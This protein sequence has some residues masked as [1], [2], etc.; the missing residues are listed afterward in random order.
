MSVNVKVDVDT[1]QVEEFFDGIQERILD[2]IKDEIYIHLVEVRN[3]AL[4]IKP[5]TTRTGQLTSS[6]FIEEIDGG[7][8]LYVDTTINESIY[9]PK[10][11]EYGRLLEFGSAHNKA[12][13]WINPAF[14]LKEPEIVPRLATAI[15]NAIDGRMPMNKAIMEGNQ[16]LPVFGNAP[17]VVVAPIQKKTGPQ[18]RL[19]SKKTGKFVS[20]KAL[21]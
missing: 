1:K 12:Y 15:Q 5:W 19:R 3:L 11:E 10:D 20:A 8:E 14:S 17:S 2:A 4:R 9:N 18:T 13:P 7:Y 6:H 16:D 21:G